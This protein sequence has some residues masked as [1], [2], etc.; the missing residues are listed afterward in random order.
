MQ[1]GGGGGGGRFDVKFKNVFTEAKQF[2]FFVDNPQFSIGSTSAS[3]GP[4]AVQSIN[5]KYSGANLQPG[6]KK[7]GKVLVTC[8]SMPH[9]PAWVF[10]LRGE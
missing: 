3:V 7:D 9:I 8:P 1:R 6:D 10:Y 5:V 2:S 4:R